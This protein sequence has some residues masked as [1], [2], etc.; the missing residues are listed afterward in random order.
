[1]LLSELAAHSSLAFGEHQWHNQNETL[2]DHWLVVESWRWGSH[3]IFTD[4]VTAIGLKSGI[5]K[6]SLNFQTSLF[7]S[8]PHKCPLGK[9]SIYLL[10]P[11]LR[12]KYLDRQDPLVLGSNQSKREKIPHHGEDKCSTIFQVCMAVQISK[13]LWRN[14][15]TYILKGPGISK[16]KK[17]VILLCRGAR[18]F[19]MCCR[20]NQQDQC[21]AFWSG[22]Q[23]G[24]VD[25]GADHSK[26]GGR[27]QKSWLRWGLI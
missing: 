14:M 13:N 23:I 22:S 24:D 25:G 26:P 1:M 2:D 19:I 8:L 11:W 20:C 7:H 3:C 12:V 27:L 18:W 15:I 6:T 10:F 21:G 4:S 5:G 9:A 17:Q 16:N